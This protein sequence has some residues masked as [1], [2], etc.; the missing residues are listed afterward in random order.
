MI[1]SEIASILSVCLPDGSAE[2][3]YC[4]VHIPFIVLIYL[5]TYLLT[6][7]MEQSPSCEGNRFSDSQ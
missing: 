7:S 2:T 3:L 6:Y 5:L 4:T 1:P